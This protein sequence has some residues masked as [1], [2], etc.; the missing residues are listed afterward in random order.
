MWSTIMTSNRKPWKP[1]NAKWVDVSKALGA[2]PP[3][4]LGS[5]ARHISHIPAWHLGRMTLDQYG[6][7]MRKDPTIDL[8]VRINTPSTK[9]YPRKATREGAAWLKGEKY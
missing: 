5:I 9:I 6:A 7:E 4:T 8:W 2:E 1:V 3:V